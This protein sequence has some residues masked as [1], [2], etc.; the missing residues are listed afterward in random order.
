MRMITNR[1][2]LLITPKEPYVQWL[3]SHDDF[4]KP[5]E[6]I[7]KQKTLYAIKSLK[8]PS[9]QNV[10]NEVKRRYKKIFHNELWSWYE[11]NFDIPQMVSFNMFNSWFTWEY[12]N[13]CNDCLRNA[14]ITEKF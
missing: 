2:F 11:D 6:N 7:Y 4:N 9:E 12:I 1:D 8:V 5:E 14:V 3:L 13:E 10:L